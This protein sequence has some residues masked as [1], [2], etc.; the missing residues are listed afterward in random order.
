MAEWEDIGRSEEFRALV[1]RRRKFVVPALLVW[2]A[3]F[4]AFIVLSGVA[5]DFMGSSIYGGFT[6]DYAWAL[7]LIVLTWAIAWLYL[8]ASARTFDPLAERAAQPQ[9]RRETF[10]DRP[11]PGREMPEPVTGGEEVRR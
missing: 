10:A 8:R 6:V 4:G 1:A 9:R 7:S 5:R 2:A 11:A 3:W